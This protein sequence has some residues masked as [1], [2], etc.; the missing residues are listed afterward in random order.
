MKKMV[1]GTLIIM[2]VTL[3]GCFYSPTKRTY[4]V[5]P[6]GSK[7]YPDALT[8]KVPHKYPNQDPPKEEGETKEELKEANSEKDKVIRDLEEKEKHYLINIASLKAM[9]AIFQ[10]KLKTAW[11]E[12]NLLRKEV[13][14]LREEKRDIKLD[15][16]ICKTNMKILE[17][18]FD[19][20]ER[21]S[22]EY[23]AKIEEFKDDED[24]MK[25]LYEKKLADANK[26]KKELTTALAKE[27]NKSY[28]FRIILHSKNKQLRTLFK[29]EISSKKIN[30][31][32]KKEDE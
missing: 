8:V 26:R 19:Q 5:K 28:E 9:I 1:I 21:E 14:R 22:R 11:E 23:L 13:A 7:S 20:K 10:G 32:C 4:E 24:D 3:C 17:S 15:L 29:E 6:R 16:A 2:C 18:D 12:N 27:S 30:K 25:K 31:L